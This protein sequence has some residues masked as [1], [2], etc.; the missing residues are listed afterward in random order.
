MNFFKSF[1]AYLFNFFKFRPLFKTFFAAFLKYF[2]L[3]R[4]FKSNYKKKTDNLASKKLILGFFEICV[5]PGSDVTGWNQLAIEVVVY[6]FWQVFWVITY[7][8]LNFCDKAGQ[9][10]SNFEGFRLFFRYLIRINYVFISKNHTSFV[11]NSILKFYTSKFAFLNKLSENVR[12][13]KRFISMFKKSM[14]FQILK[15]R[16]KSKFSIFCYFFYLKLILTWK[17]CFGCAIGFQIDI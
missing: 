12:I 7:F 10:S 2:S 14:F 4:H 8:L 6:K 9:F 1:S 13:F 11:F 5:F 17:F 16:S 3:I 15:T